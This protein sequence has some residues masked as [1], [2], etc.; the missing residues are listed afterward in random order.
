MKGYSCSCSLSHAFKLELINY[1][2]Y[3]SIEYR[4]KATSDFA[5]LEGIKK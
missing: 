3:S 1:I 4:D 2:S 5:I